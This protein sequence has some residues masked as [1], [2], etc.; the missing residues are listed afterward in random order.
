MN[1][2]IGA[3]G[4]EDGRPTRSGAAQEASCH[5]ECEIC[6]GEATGHE[7]EA[8]AVREIRENGDGGD[9]PKLSS[10]GAGYLAERRSGIRGRTR[11][12]HDTGVRTMSPAA[13]RQQLLRRGKGKHGRRRQKRAENT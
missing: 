13:N 8:D 9:S 3:L 6:P 2:E 11:R 10:V 1:G 12:T 4:E 7:A 5:D